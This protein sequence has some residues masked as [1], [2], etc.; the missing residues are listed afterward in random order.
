[1]ANERSWEGGGRNGALGLTACLAALMGTACPGGPENPCGGITCSGYGRCE[2]VGG[3]PACRCDDGF[4]PDGLACIDPTGTV[5]TTDQVVDG[6][7][8][9]TFDGQ[10]RFGRYANGDFWVLG[11]VTVR[12]VAPEFAGD[13]HGWEVNPDDVVAQGFDGRIA[14]YDAARVPTLPY[15]ADPGQSLVKGVSLEPLDDAGCR[16]CLRAASVLTVVGATPADD[17]AT[18]FRPPYFGAAK[19]EYSTTRLRP[20]RLPSLA[21]T[22]RAPGLEATAQRFR[23]VFLDHKTNWTGR[24]LHPAEHLPDYGSDIAVRT[25]EGALQLACAGTD[26][27]RRTALVRYV[28]VGIDLYQMA[29]G[30]Q[31]W[32]PGGGHG[33]GRK[34]PVAFA[35]LLLDDAAMTDFVNGA[36]REQFGE[37]GGMYRSERGGVVLFGQTPNSEESYWRNLVFDSGSRTIIDPYGWIDGGH[38]PGGSY[39]F[40]CTAKAWKATAAAVRLIP[41]LEAVWSHPEFFEY[42]DRWVASGAWTQP[43]PCAPPDGVCTGG[44][45]AGTRCTSASAHDVCTGDE[46]ACDLTVHWDDHY[47][48]T[49]GPDGA[50]G[51]IADDDPA[52]GAGRFPGLHGANADGGHHGS[53]FGD[54]M[55]ATH[56]AG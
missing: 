43:D 29:L 32:P 33:E 6:S 52:D 10:V 5:R 2:L 53:A 18:V 25:A 4:E 45:A 14:D 22:S 20:D 47:G 54:E 28:Q 37:N 38:E 21:C 11:P 15:R 26:A 19:P 42:V 49:Y 23:G 16:P 30:G 9:W 7:V 56:V 55:W 50:G 3:E 41:G 24:P 27:E 36:D 35:A 8:V 46:G 44:T 40:C 34:L 17:G 13:R 48:V 31:T 1:M 39:Q 51:C 12:R